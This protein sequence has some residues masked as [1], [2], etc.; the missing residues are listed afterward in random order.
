[1]SVAQL[2][3]ADAVAHGKALATFCA[4][5]GENFAAVGGG[6]SFAEAV[7]VHALAVVGLISTFHCRICVIIC[8]YSSIREAKLINISDMAK[9]SAEKI[10]PLL[11]T[12]KCKITKSSHRTL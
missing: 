5:T 2:L 12:S 3:A 1:M 10:V 6:H 8:Y 7:L 11:S 4:T 9:F